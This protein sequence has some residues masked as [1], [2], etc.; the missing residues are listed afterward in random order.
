MI[1]NIILILFILVDYSFSSNYIILCSDHDSY[2]R[3]FDSQT[4]SNII[5]E[6]G[7]D[8]LHLWIAYL[9]NN[10]T[11]SRYFFNLHFLSSLV[12]VSALYVIRKHISTSKFIYICTIPILLSIVYIHLWSCAYRHGISSSLLFFLWIYLYKERFIY[13][14]KLDSIYIFL[15]SYLSLLAHWSSIFLLP[16]ITIRYFDNLRIYL[17]KAILS[18]KIK[19]MLLIV[20]TLITSITFYLI[21]NTNSLDHILGK[22]LSY[23]MILQDVL[24][25]NY[26]TKVT[27]VTLLAYSPSVFLLITNKSIPIKANYGFDHLYFSPLYFIFLMSFISFFGIGGVLVRTWIPISL[28]VPALNILFY[29]YANKL[30]KLSIVYSSSIILLSSLFYINSS[31]PNLIKESFYY[32][33]MSKDML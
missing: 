5:P 9:T 11:Y 18:F 32:L 13:K 23:S 15:L 6:L 28:I 33:G 7:I 21:F 26:G 25:R 30:L 24:T 20:I 1:K 10:S 17:F 14:K 16:F 2:A 31:L 22:F 8:R 3:I 12:Y 29:K 27:L 19:Y 4:T